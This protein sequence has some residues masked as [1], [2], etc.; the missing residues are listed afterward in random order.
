MNDDNDNINGNTQQLSGRIQ[1]NSLSSVPPPP[2]QLPTPPPTQL[3]P[4]PPPTPT[5]TP[6]TTSTKS[7]E[8]KP[9]VLWKNND[10]IIND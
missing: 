7:V 5:P 4:T 1:S 3:P 10:D 8:K 2:T 6:R 9:I